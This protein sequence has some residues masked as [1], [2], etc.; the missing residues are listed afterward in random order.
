MITMWKNHHDINI[1]LIIRT[2][3]L[4]TCKTLTLWLIQSCNQR[5]GILFKEPFFAE[6]QLESKKAAPTVINYLS[7]NLHVLAFNM[8]G[9]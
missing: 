1:L 2:P 6:K 5:K 3:L 7:P 4:I 8:F 9:N